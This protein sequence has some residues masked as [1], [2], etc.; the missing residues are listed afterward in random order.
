[1]LGLRL[2]WSFL[3]RYF[4]DDFCRHAADYDIGRN[5]LI[6]YRSGRHNRIVAD[7]DALQDGRVRA[8]PHIL[9]QHYRCRVSLLAVLG[10]QAVV[11]RGQHDVVSYL[12]SVADG[13]AAMVLKMAAGIDKDI[14]PDADILAEI[15]IKR[16]EYT[17]R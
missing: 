17:Q 8:Y 7:S 4:L 10:R 15:R 2:A 5:I 16:R 12:A 11:Q 3:R 9:A 1:M 13:N 14:L 6:D